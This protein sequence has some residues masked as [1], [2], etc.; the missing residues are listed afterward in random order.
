MASPAHINLI[1]REKEDLEGVKKG[2]EDRTR[3]QLKLTKKARAQ[4]R[5]MTRGRAQVAEGGGLDE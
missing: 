4:R 3:P 5:Y 2:K 1:F